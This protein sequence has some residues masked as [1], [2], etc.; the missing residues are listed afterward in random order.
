MKSFKQYLLESKTDN[1][2]H[3]IAK[4]VMH[5]AK[6]ATGPETEET[7][8]TSDLYRSN[9]PDLFIGEDGVDKIEKI[10]TN[11]IDSKDYN[12]K[13][14]HVTGR[15][16]ESSTQVGMNGVYNTT[17]FIRIIL[18]RGELSKN[19]KGINPLEYERVY[20]RIVNVL[21][22]EIEHTLQKDKSSSISTNGMFSDK[23]DQLAMF[24]LA[25]RHLHHVN[26]KGARAIGGYLQAKKQKTSLRNIYRNEI[27][28]MIERNIS[29]LKLNEK[30]ANELYNSVEGIVEDQIKIIEKKIGHT[31][32]GFMV[33]Q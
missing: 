25:K 9:I 6:Q 27:N 8:W 1:I 19:L 3:Y 29:Q 23:R 18:Y 7:I 30:D 17:G 33:G 12:K 20:M 26:E 24:D 28:T 4:V 21:R 32:D 22:H 14:T 31:I 10:I 15:V 11:V 13:Y 5:I 2:S 16:H